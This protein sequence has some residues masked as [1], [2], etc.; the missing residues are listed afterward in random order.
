MKRPRQ[1]VIAVSVVLGGIAV[2]VVAG[3]LLRGTIVKQ[4]IE[5]MNGSVR[6]LDQEAGTVFELSLPVAKEETA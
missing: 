3:M 1:K 2:L 5:Q 6:L 4:R